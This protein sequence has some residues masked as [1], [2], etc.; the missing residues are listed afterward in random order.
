MPADKGQR[1]SMQRLD[2]L[3]ARL[4][5][6]VRVPNL[7]ERRRAPGAPP[8]YRSQT[9]GGAAASSLEQ[10]QQQQPSAYAFPLSDERPLSSPPRF[11]AAFVADRLG[12][13]HDAERGH[14]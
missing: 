6:R 11:V 13:P 5:A 14:R 2:E 1:D 9:H 12:L 8:P 10:G 4:P 3:I 7:A